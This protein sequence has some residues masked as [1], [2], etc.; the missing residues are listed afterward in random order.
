MIRN[1]ED[2]RYLERRNR[3][4]QFKMQQRQ[5]WFAVDDDDEA[6]SLSSKDQIVSRKVNGK[7]R[8]PRGKMR[9]Y[10]PDWD[11]PELLFE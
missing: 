1:D 2:L 3:R 11:E 8:K 7:P 10:Q 6:E 9:R 5:A 4:E